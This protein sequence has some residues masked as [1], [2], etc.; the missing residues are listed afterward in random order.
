MDKKLAGYKT[1]ESTKKAKSTKKET[2]DADV[3]D[4]V[5]PIPLAMIPGP[6]ATPHLSKEIIEGIGIDFLQIQP[7]AISAALLDQ[8]MLDD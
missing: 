5:D 1:E 8:D 7:E 2:L 4:A 3:E 6:A